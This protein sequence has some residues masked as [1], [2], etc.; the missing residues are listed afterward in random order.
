MSDE[1][2]VTATL[3]VLKNTLKD[4]FFKDLYIT[5][6]GTDAFHGTQTIGTSVEALSIGDITTPGWM[7][8]F[9]NDE[10]NYITIRNGSG[11]A[12]VVKIGAQECALFRLATTTPYAIANTAACQVEYLLIED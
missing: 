8:I 2:H 6:S 4:S 5:M 12:D 10:D 1:I 9:N 11:G 3:S 7:L